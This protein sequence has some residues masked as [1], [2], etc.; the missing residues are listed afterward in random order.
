MNSQ[1]IATNNKLIKLFSLKPVII[2]MGQ[3]SEPLEFFSFIGRA[4]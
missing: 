1:E 3:Q 4:L 2:S